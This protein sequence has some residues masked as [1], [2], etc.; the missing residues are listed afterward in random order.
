MMQ[1]NDAS[2]VDRNAPEGAAQIEGQAR[3]E[4]ILQ[5]LHE[6]YPDARC[7]LDFRSPFELLVATIL[8]AQCTDVRV[9]QVTPILFARY[10]GPEDF[11]A[12]DRVELENAIRST[13]FFHRKA[14]YIQES[15]RL[16]LAVFGGEVPQEM[17]QLL[18]LP[19]VSRKTANVVLG[20]AF[21]RGEGVVVDTHVQRL[22]GRL[23][24]S[25]SGDPVRIER[26]LMAIAPRSEWVVLPHLLIQHGRDTCHARRPACPRCALQ[27]HLPGLCHR[28][29]P[30]RK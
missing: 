20:N 1:G 27:R 21:G 3:L 17:D 29:H 5:R 8:S 23:G 18:Q 15:S 4:V 24:L 26:D 13:G 22:S 9:N 16:L 11:A 10:P 30:R 6:L 14:E 2:E 28:D 12:A 25:Q 7:S 19:G